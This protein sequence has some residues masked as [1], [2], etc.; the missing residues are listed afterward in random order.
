MCRSPERY[1]GHRKGCCRAAIARITMN[2]ERRLPG[3][4]KNTVTSHCVTKWIEQVKAGESAA[5]QRLWERYLSQLAQSRLAGSPQQ[6]A[7]A[8]DVAV[9]AFEKFLHYAQAGRFP[10][11]DDRFDRWQ[12]LLLVTDQK[13]Q[14]TRGGP[15][16]PPSEEDL[17]RVRWQAPAVEP[18]SQDLSGNRPP[19][20]QR[21]SSSSPHQNSAGDCWA[22]CK[23]TKCIA[24]RWEMCMG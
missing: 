19:P 4:P 7:D 13:W 20:S 6:V 21:R 8:E 9:V 5:A 14:S 12:V 1:R 3:G 22:C 16:Q 18:T 2:C 11:L 10:R 15:N 24:S 17:S 23:T